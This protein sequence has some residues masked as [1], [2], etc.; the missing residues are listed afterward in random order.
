M[1]RILTSISRVSALEKIIFLVTL[2]AGSSALSLALTLWIFELPFSELNFKTVLIVLSLRL[3]I[4]GILGMYRFLLRYASIRAVITTLNAVL[5]SEAVIM[6]INWMLD[7]GLSTRIF[8][9]DTFFVIFLVGG[10]RLA[11]RIFRELLIRQKSNDQDE[12]LTLIVGAGDGAELITREI[13]R[14]ERLGKI[15]I[16]GYLDDD[17]QKWGKRLHGNPVI[18]PIDALE[19][20]VNDLDVKDVIIAIPSANG[21]LIRGII[22]H[23]DALNVRYKIT[24]TMSELSTGRARIG[25]LRE[26]NIEDLL[27][28]QMI[29]KDLIL[30]NKTL[31][32]EVV[33]VT[34]AGG[35]IGSELCR[36]IIQLLPKKLIMLD[37]SE[38]A[39]YQIDLE[40]TNAA[41]HS[42][43]L[44]SIVGD[45]KDK[46]LLDDVVKKY[47]VSLIYH[48]AAYKHVPLMEANVPAVLHNNIVGTR[49]LVE[50]AMAHQV[51]QFVLIST[52]KA[53]NPSSV[54]GASKRICEMIVLS[55]NS[56]KTQFSAVRFGNVL[57]SNGSVVPL[58]QKQIQMGG[59]VTITHPEVT[60]Y[61]MTIPEAVCLVIQA[62]HLRQGKAV[63]ILDMGSPVKILSLARDLIKLSNEDEEGIE[64]VYTGLRP[65]EKLHEE[66][67][68]PKEMLFSTHNS[69]ISYI[70]PNKIEAEVLTQKL[71]MLGQL[72]DSDR[73]RDELIALANYGYEAHG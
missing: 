7:L 5:L 35:S 23:C 18:G 8:L 57:G 3:A 6:A 59:P 51:R 39:L 17:P 21:K 30:D 56:E 71:E 26:V 27:G 9:L 14:S 28:R 66:L 22:D 63:F 33:M 37:H 29:E 69:K 45:I 20:A 54:M 15:R 12:T 36:Q 2:D 25:Q 48:A 4:F 40:L 68:Y 46:A 65:G 50:V 52:D 70:I 31:T 42:V 49:N 67:I 11:L 34:G 58:F 19:S 38:H 55:Q 64:I 16:V 73:L 10:I 61:F 13:M 44:V 60:R 24:P 47:K 32:G 53:V 41:Q 62:S 72:T 43:T 1:R